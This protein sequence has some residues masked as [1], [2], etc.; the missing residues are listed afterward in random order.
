MPFSTTDFWNPS[1]VGTDA[2]SEYITIELLS[3][4]NKTA[5]TNG[6]ARMPIIKSS[7]I[8][9]EAALKTVVSEGA[10]TYY[11]QGGEQKVDFEFKF[12][13]GDKA[14]KDIC[15]VL[16]GYNLRITKEESKFDINGMHQWIILPYCRAQYTF[17]NNKPGTEGVIKGIGMAC[18]VQQTPSMVTLTSGH[19]KTSAVALLTIPA[20][21]YHQVYEEVIA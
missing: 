7:V 13:Q 18:P 17:E 14:S 9:D 2:G 1:A 19:S 10:N 3:T 12:I 20:G 8:K 16:K 6:I 5:I 21:T 15:N 11:Q 4:D